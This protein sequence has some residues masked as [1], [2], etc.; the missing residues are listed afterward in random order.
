M[1]NIKDAFLTLTTEEVTR[2]LEL[3]ARIRDKDQISQL[4]MWEN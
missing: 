4:R 2:V 1:M 3:C